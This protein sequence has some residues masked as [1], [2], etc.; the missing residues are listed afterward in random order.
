MRCKKIEGMNKMTS[1]PGTSLCQADRNRE[2]L[3]A[4]EVTRVQLQH[5]VLRPRA[6][7]GSSQWDETDW[8]ED[9]TGT[10]SAH[11]TSAGVWE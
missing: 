11:R 6:T 3:K 2:G 4:K 10:R 1:V 9:E 8:E 7:P 5:L